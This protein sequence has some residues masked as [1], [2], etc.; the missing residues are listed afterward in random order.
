MLFD[1]ASLTDIVRVPGFATRRTL[2]ISLTHATALY[3]SERAGAAARVHRA[4]GTD[5]AA[6][7]RRSTH[8][9]QGRIA[10]VAR[11]ST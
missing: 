10:A 5:F 7:I 8:R 6:P 4:V 1:L 2:D 11:A 3:K 9:S